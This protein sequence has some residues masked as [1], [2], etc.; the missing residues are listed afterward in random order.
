MISKVF[1]FG[2][3][4]KYKSFIL[5]CCVCSAVFM[6]LASFYRCVSPVLVDIWQSPHNDYLRQHRYVSS[7]C[8]YVLQCISSNNRMFFLIICVLLFQVWFVQ[9]NLQPCYSK[10]FI[11]LCFLVVIFMTIFIIFNLLY[12][13][14][15][16][17]S[18]KPTLLKFFLLVQKIALPTRTF[19][20]FW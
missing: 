20:L 14:L 11:I 17:V 9:K 8:W 7:C 5:F 6:L 10:V 1:C 16:N 4:K 18:S 13:L 3:Q 15:L 19:L 12:L 2:K